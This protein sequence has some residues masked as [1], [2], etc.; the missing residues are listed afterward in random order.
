MLNIRRIS[1]QQHQMCV[2]QQCYQPDLGVVTPKQGA[3]YFQ[4][5]LVGAD[6]KVKALVGVEDW[7]NY[8]WP[9]LNHY[10]WQS[11]D[12]A[13]LIS[14][15]D[16]EY[17]GTLFFSEHFRCESLEIIDDGGAQVHWLCVRES[18]LGQVL[19]PSPIKGLS[20]KSAQNRLLNSLKL[21]ADWVLGHSHISAKLLQ[22]I[23]L[24]DVFYIQQLQLQ[25]SIAGRPFARFQKQQEGQFMIEEIMDSEVENT[26][27]TETEDFVAEA[28][29]PFDVNAMTV[30]LTFV[31]GHR[32]IAV[33]ELAN[34]QPGSVF[35]IGEHKE[36]EVKV[37]ANKQLVAEGE[38][39]YI[40][41]S[42]ELGLEI[43][44]LSSGEKRS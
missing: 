43:T 16:A 19:L 5:T 8:H 33:N 31:L 30:K 26:E 23:E 24:H 32:E 7:C 9:S 17:R 36:R 15:F 13:N 38:L 10:A 35:S 21:Q 39:I 28:V 6:E 20:V 34:I 22:S 4:L 3:R 2:W 42:D 44:R 40:G 1:Q 29:Q 18:N 27:L 12:D 37:Y 25:M 11:V 41:D 14:L